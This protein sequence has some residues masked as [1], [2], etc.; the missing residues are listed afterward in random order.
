MLS[1]LE[2]G[3]RLQFYAKPPRFQGIMPTVLRDAAER[4]SL[5]A[6]IAALLE[7]GA[8]MLLPSEEMGQGFYS[9]FFLIPKRDG[10]L[11]P[12]LDLEGV[13]PVSEASAF[14]DAFPLTPP[15]V[16]EARRLVLPFSRKGVRAQGSPLWPVTGSPHLYKMYGRGTPSS[17]AS[18]CLHSELDDWLICAPS[19]RQA[20]R[21]TEVVLAIFAG[22]AWP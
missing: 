15:F 8:V 18:G 16:R 12:I 19:E 14:S 3:Y 20:R 9:A 4:Q 5:S 1:T 6:E 13:Q 7:K 17:P 10:G 22:W 21:D 11:R 2:Y